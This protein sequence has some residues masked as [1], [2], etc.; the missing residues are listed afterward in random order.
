MSE[1]LLLDRIKNKLLMADPVYFAEKYLTIDGEPFRLQKGGWKPFA[2]IYRYVGIKA[3]EKGSKPVVIVAARQVGKTSLAAAMEMYFCGSGVFGNGKNP[4]IRMI[5]AFPQLDLAFAYSK[6]KLTAMINGSLAIDGDAQANN[7]KVKS[8]M[9]SLIDSTSE[10]NNSL[11]FK[12][13]VGGNHLWVESVGVD[14]NRMRGKTVDVIFFDE[15]QLMFSSAISNSLKVLTQAKYGEP[16]QGVQVFFGTPLLRGSTYWDMWHAS[17]QQYYH[18]GCEKCKKLF[19]LYT[20]GTNDWEEIWIYGFT[21]RCSHCGFEQ[22]KNQAAERGKWVALKNQTDAQFIGFHINQLYIPT[23]TKEKIISEK[24]ENNT[25]N[26]EKAYQNEVLGEFYHGEATIITPDQIR[27][28][29]G[30]PERKFRKQILPDDDLLVFLGIDIGAKNDLAQLAD[31]NRVRVQ[32]Q[33]YST[34]V[35][36]AMTGPQRMSIE[37]ATMFKR[38]DLASKKGLIEELMRKYS[39]NLG[40]CD[41]GFANDLN[42]IIQTEYG[43]K[44]LSSEAR[45]KVNDHI[46]FNSDVFPKVIVFERD[47]WIADMYEQMKKGNVRFPMGDYEKVSWLIQHCTSMEIKPSL[48]R[49][50][51]VTPHYVKGGSPNDGFAALVNA[52]LAYRF[53]VSE[54]FKIKHPSLMKDRKAPK[55]MAILGYIPRM[56]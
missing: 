38:N 40:V 22:D 53:Y 56:K 2:D 37:F 19:P 21:V 26:T 23:Y 33:S 24:P 12:Q 18:L 10:S 48:S 27:D 5:H 54:G 4:P 6:V 43:D 9:Q 25:I 51:D 29:C 39:V 14:G 15:V 49:T 3:V 46:K 45:S 7:K 31:S 20:P 34:A 44:F 50:G 13:F 36:I 41:L 16:G 28:V 1:D 32:G 8:Y 17:S 47:Y 30:D 52:Y 55:P 11:Q 35:V 42:E